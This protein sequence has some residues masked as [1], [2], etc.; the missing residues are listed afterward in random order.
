MS[1]FLSTFLLSNLAFDLRSSLGTPP[2]GQ[3]VFLESQLM[4]SVLSWVCV[5]QD[6]PGS[7]KKNFF[8]SIISERKKRRGKEPRTEEGRKQESYHLF[9]LNCHHCIGRL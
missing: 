1:R 7:L 3:K 4:V 6:N 2:S 9:F 8:L 5:S